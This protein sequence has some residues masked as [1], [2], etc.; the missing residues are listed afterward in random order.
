MTSRRRRRYYVVVVALL[1]ASLLASSGTSNTA[2][3]LTTTTTPSFL[4]HFRR[5]S[6]L[7]AQEV[8]FCARQ[9]RAVVERP[10]RD[11]G[12]ARREEGS[13]LQRRRRQCRLA[14]SQLYAVSDGGGGGAAS[15]PATS[16]LKKKKQRRRRSSSTTTSSSSVNNADQLQTRPGDDDET[17]VAQAAANGTTTTTSDDDDSSDKKIVLDE[18]NKVVVESSSSTS[19]VGGSSTNAD[20]RDDDDALASKVDR[21]LARRVRDCAANIVSMPSVEVA[22]TLLVLLSSLLVALATLDD[23]PAN[24]VMP[25]E[26]AENFVAYAFLF[27]FLLRW[28]ATTLPPLKYA[29]KPLVLVDFVVVVLPFVV[30]LASQTELGRSLPVWLISN[31]A[32]INLRLLRILRVQRVLRDI[33]TFQRF[34]RAV[35]ISTEIKAWQ[36][37]LA[38]VMLSI[39]TLLSVATGLIYTAEHRVNPQITDYFTALYFGLTT[40]TTV[41]TFLFCSNFHYCLIW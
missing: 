30:G 21:S 5:W 31:N 27:E 8:F 16:S 2:A 15:P 6:S 22:S 14:G 37:Q 12:W 26:V 33:D 41:G 29:S 4:T 10:S 28:L 17:G 32:L 24:V 11:V 7:R 1:L 18:E 9:P 39:F 40:L 34:E 23:L 19:E 25:L 13:L 3:A 36:L 35:G 38:R 20:H